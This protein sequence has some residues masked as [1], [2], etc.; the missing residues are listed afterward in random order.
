MAENHTAVVF[1]K[2]VQNGAI[3][4]DAHNGA[5]D[6]SVV[7]RIAAAGYSQN[8]LPFYRPENWSMYWTTGQL[9]TAAQQQA[10][11]EA[12]HAGLF[13]DDPAKNTGEGG[14]HRLAMLDPNM[15]EMGAAV[16]F[17]QFQGNNTCLLYTS[18]CV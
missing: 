8:G 18:R 15:K 2:A 17:G 5:G 13:Y 1:N 10:A 3:N 11:I 16:Q 9:S 7:A 6:G 14:G 12:M 4:F